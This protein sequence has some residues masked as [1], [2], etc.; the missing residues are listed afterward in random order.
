MSAH[1]EIPGLGTRT[2]R[3]ARKAGPCAG[4]TQKYGHAIIEAGDRYWESE[5]DPYT[6]GGY[7]MKRCCIAC[8]PVGT[9]HA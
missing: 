9:Y 4:W 2:I 1:I 3:T 6:A 8:L 5:P 7:G